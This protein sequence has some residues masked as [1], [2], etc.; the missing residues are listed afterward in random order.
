MLT[1]TE[2]TKDFVWEDLKFFLSD[3]SMIKELLTEIDQR[4]HGL[5][6]AYR[7]KGST[8]VDDCIF[9]MAARREQPDNVSLTF[10]FWKPWVGMKG[11][12]DGERMVYI[13]AGFKKFHC[14]LSFFKMRFFFA[15]ILKQKDKDDVKADNTKWG[16]HFDLYQF[17][18]SS[19][20]KPKLPPLER[21]K[22]M[23]M[24]K[25]GFTATEDNC[26]MYKGEKLRVATEE[27]NKSTAI[28]VE[29]I[30][31]GPE[32]Q[33]KLD[34]MDE[35]TRREE[36]SR[37]NAE[38]SQ[39]IQD[40]KAAFDNEEKF[41]DGPHLDENANQKWG[42][43]DKDE[44]K[45]LLAG[46]MGEEAF[47]ENEK[48]TCYGVTGLNNVEKVVKNMIDRNNWGVD[49]E[50]SVKM[51]EK[52]RR[53]RNEAEAD[54]KKLENLFVKDQREAVRFL[55]ERFVAAKET[56]ARNKVLS[57][58]VKTLRSNI[59][60]RAE[61]Y[62]VNAEKFEQQKKKHEEE[63]KAMKRSREGD[64]VKT[65]RMKEDFATFKD[66]AKAKLAVTSKDLEE[67][68]EQVKIREKEVKELR[69]ENRKRREEVKEKNVEIMTIIGE[70]EEAN[71]QKAHL[72]MLA[73]EN[74]EL[75]SQ[76]RQQKQQQ[77]QSKEKQQLKSARSEI[78]K[79]KRRIEALQTDEM[80]ERIEG[81]DLKCDEVTWLLSEIG[82]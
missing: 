76:L 13:K 23:L 18:A 77:K 82:R 61:N 7:Q 5:G 36:E 50:N 31:H 32:N 70:R 21:V 9:R 34:A 44:L 45:K 80:G 39:I 8:Y 79:L 41:G 75:R 29:R 62:E 48:V 63:L 46:M 37:Q 40:M 12:V 16:Y 42:S 33:K 26:L 55:R 81:S 11:L 49:Q 69:K 27:M 25:F 28:T 10:M 38:W 43:D 78:E 4:A 3:A 30:G 68:I 54:L 2:K 58:L 74:V 15:L 67:A 22:Q 65:L 60:K 51:T 19:S 20:A 52:E 35:K 14:Y 6:Y 71:R 17:L 57:D 72:E 59:D 64:E 73:N 66:L 1:Y 53:I 56:E 47:S 24:R